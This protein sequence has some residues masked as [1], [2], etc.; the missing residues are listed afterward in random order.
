M[1]YKRIYPSI[2]G[3]SGASKTLELDRAKK[4]GMEGRDAVAHGLVDS[5]QLL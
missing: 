5:F 1:L 2:T 4:T 3:Q